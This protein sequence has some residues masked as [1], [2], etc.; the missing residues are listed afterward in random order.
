MPRVELTD[1][2]RRRGRALGQTI[3]RLRGKKAAADL[4]AA[5]GVRLD[6]LRKFEQGRIPTPGFFFIA[7]V[8]WALR[9]DL[10]GLNAEMRRTA[11]EEAP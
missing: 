4:A 2:Q 8:A 7:D 10:D 5:A 9:V 3:R 11:T 1:E 6:T